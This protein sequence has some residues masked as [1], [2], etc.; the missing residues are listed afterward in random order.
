MLTAGSPTSAVF[1]LEAD[2]KKIAVV[3]SYAASGMKSE[4]VI[5]AFGKSE[6]V[7]AITNQPSYVVE[8]T[9]LYATDEAISD[10]IDFHKLENFSL[11]IVKPDRR[12]VYTGCNWSE[13]AEDGQLSEMVAERI[14]VVAARRV[15]TDNS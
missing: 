2:V 10:G 9:R 6:P 12:V 13:I 8:L 1:Y 3:Q 7:A 5:E 14:R 11:V 4:R 15:E